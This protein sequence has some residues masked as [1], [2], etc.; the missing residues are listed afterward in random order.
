MIQEKIQ[1]LKPDIVLDVGCRRGEN[2]VK[3]ASYCRHITAIDVV[4][5]SIEKAKEENARDNISYLVM[6]G[7]RIGFPDNNFDLVCE[8]MSLHHIK[9][10]QTALD[11]MIRVSSKYILVEEPIND[12]RSEAKKNSYQAQKFFLELQQEVG[13]FHFE[14]IKPEILIEAFEERGLSFEHEFSRTDKPETFDEYFEPFDFFVQKSDREDY[15]RSRLEDFRKEMEGKSFCMSD[16][17]LI[18]AMK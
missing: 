6:D 18:T 7:R 14:F 8:G 13:F 4:T 11:E 2:I 17:I 10:W 9:E 1:V 5:E 16:I 15:W 12:L 3:L